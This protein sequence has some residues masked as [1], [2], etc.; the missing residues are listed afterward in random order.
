[1][2]LKL[3]AVHNVPVSHING[4]IAAV[5]SAA[6]SEVHEEISK[7][8]IWRIMLEGEV[9]ESVQLV[10]EISKVQGITLSSDGTSHKNINYAAHHITYSGQG[11][12]S[13]CGIMRFVGIQCEFN[14]TS[15]TQL[16]G[17]Q[18]LTTDMY[19]TYNEYMDTQVDSQECVEKV[20]GM[21]TNHT[22]DPKKLVC[23][24]WGWKQACEQEVRG[25]RALAHLP[26]HEVAQLT[27]KKIEQVIEDAGG[28]EAWVTL[29]VSKQ[30][31]RVETTHCAMHYEI[32]VEFFNL[33]SQAKKDTT[34]FFIWGS[35][36]MHKELNA[37][38]GG[39][40]V[41]TLWWHD[42]NIDPPI[43]LMNQDNATAASS[44]SLAAVS[45]TLQVSGH[46]A[47]KALD[48][49]GI[50]FH[51]KDDKKGQQDSLHYYLEAQL[52]YFFPWP[53]TSNTQYQSHCDG[54]SA[55]LIYHP[56][57]TSYLE[58]VMDWKDSCT[59]T[60]IEQN[61]HQAFRCPKTA[62][63]MACLSMWG[64]CVSHPYM[65]Q[66]RGEFHDFSNSLNLSPLHAQLF[67]HL[68]TLAATI[69]LILAPDVTYHTAALDGKPFGHLDAFYA[70]QMMV[71][72]SQ[73]YPHL[74]SLLPAFLKGATKTLLRFTTEFLP[75]GAIVR[76]TLAQR[77][78]ACMETTNDANEG[79][80]GI[81]RVAL[82]CAP[83]MTTVQFNARLKY[84][85]NQMGS[86]M[87]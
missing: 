54:A 7:R 13:K 3:V 15:E 57:Y 28:F 19:T 74:H 27:W 21:L 31:K 68:N 43:V 30:K 8:S 9:A 58:I 73:T 23:L 24:F 26:L 45:H 41:M 47:V 86:Y 10:D 87:Q 77:E 59:H 61:V 84:H 35:C 55:W 25:E 42:N 16:E 14:H 51:H 71:R 44:G 52:G 17:W 1:M 85:K 18:G 79:A 70:V 32:G 80:L 5:S 56:L 4:V 29:Q 48:L 20:K 38:K 2:V 82:R 53:D 81:Y 39:N 65:Q 66:V 72:D 78:L 6:R 22:E 64:N 34:N 75:D 40:S 46:G 83:T 69:N 12:E 11:E 76:S 67:S 50:V 37:V 63:E 36:C 33:L 62:E 60:N 49:T